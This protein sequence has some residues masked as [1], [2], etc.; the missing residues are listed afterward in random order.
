MLDLAKCDLADSYDI[1]FTDRAIINLNTEKRQ[2]QVID[3]LA[4]RVASGGLLLLLENFVETY[5]RQN[6]CRELLG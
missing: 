2:L 5:E 3:A 4:T 1:V 6:D